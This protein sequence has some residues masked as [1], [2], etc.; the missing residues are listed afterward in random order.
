[1]SLDI[2]LGQRRNYECY[3]VRKA[4][5]VIVVFWDLNN[6]A[7]LILKDVFAVHHGFAQTVAKCVSQNV[8]G[9]NRQRMLHGDLLVGLGIADYFLIFLGCIHINCTKIMAE[10]HYLTFFQCL[11]NFDMHKLLL[12]CFVQNRSGKIQLEHFFAVGQHRRVL[13]VVHLYRHYFGFQDVAYQHLGYLLVLH[14]V[15]EDGVVY[16]VNYV[17]HLL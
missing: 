13:V 1:M 14:Y 7:V 9:M 3:S 6:V 12:T 16:R 8:D 17:C 2:L 5:D 15:F 10:T 11:L 4:V